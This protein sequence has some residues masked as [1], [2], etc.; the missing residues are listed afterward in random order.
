MSVSLRDVIFIPIPTASSNSTNSCKAFFAFDSWCAY[1]KKNYGPFW[2]QHKYV[3]NSYE[4]LIYSATFHQEKKT[5]FVFTQDFNG[6]FGHFSQTW[7][8]FHI[9]IQFITKVAV[10]KQTLN[11]KKNVFENKKSLN[12]Y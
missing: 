12:Y 2:S 1:L 3:L 7:L 6:L 10:R 9:F 11:Q 5:I 4:Y 8:F